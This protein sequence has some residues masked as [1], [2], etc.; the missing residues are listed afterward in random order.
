[1]TVPTKV[2]GIVLVTGPVNIGKTSFAFHTGYA[3]SEYAYYSFDSKKPVIGGDKPESVLGFYREYLGEM[4]TKRELAMIEM[5]LNDIQANKSNNKLKVAVVDGEEMFRKNFAAYTKHNKAKL[6]DYWYGRGGIW[7]AYE[8]LGFAKKFEASLFTS[9]QEQYEL[10]IIIN[11]LEGV[12][13]ESSEKEEKPLIPGKKKADTKEELIKKSAVR[14]WLVPTDGNLCPSAIVLK[15]PGYHDWT[16]EGIKTISLFPPKLSPMAVPGWE[17][18]DF[19]SLWDVIKHYEQHPFSSKYPA[20]EPYEMLT[21]EEQEMVSDDLSEKDRQLIEQIAL[22][23]Q[24][25]NHERVV[26]QVREIMVEKPLAPSVF[27]YN[28]IKA[29]LPDVVITKDSIQAVMDE[30]KGE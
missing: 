14:F 12:R 28:K 26:S 21:V 10:V 27:V 22:V 23:I 9:L 11:H 30:L 7:Q 29:I 4:A 19:I 16:E 3:P 18:M 13:D 5:F 1:M 8:E 17:E 25:E 6:R 24:K 2:K 15:N 20:I